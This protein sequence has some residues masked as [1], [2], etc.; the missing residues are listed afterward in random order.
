MAYDDSHSQFFYP[1][2]DFRE[3][4]MAFVNV[5]EDYFGKGIA[6]V[7]EEK[8]DC[9]VGGCVVASSLNSFLSLSSFF[10]HGPF[11][12]AQSTR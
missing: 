1:Y 12:S 4:A 2:P 8:R 7:R 5:E 11:G 3:Y 9:A 6:Q 10:T